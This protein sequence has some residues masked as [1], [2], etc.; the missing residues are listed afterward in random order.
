MIT[1]LAAAYVPISFVTVSSLFSFAIV[2]DPSPT[3]IPWYE[4]YKRAYVPDPQ[5]E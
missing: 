4:R 3:V 2:A 1:L 5:G